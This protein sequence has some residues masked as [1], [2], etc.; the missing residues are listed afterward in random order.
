MQKLQGNKGKAERGKLKAKSRKLKAKSGKLKGFKHVN[1]V[2]ALEEKVI[3]EPIKDLVPVCLN[4]HA[5][6]NRKKGL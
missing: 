2:K 5:M 1:H 3:I 4:F 6:L